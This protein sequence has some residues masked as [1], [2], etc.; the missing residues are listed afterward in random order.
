MLRK[1]FIMKGL[2]PYLGAE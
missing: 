1:V 2:C